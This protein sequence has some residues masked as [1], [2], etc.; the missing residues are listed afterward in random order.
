[1]E[2]TFGRLERV[3]LRKVWEKE[4][5]DF[6]PWLAQEEH[7]QNLGNAIGIELEFEAQEKEVGLFRA[8]ILCKNTLDNS[9]VLTV[10]QLED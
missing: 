8:D 9:W 3:D 6:T 2:K 10:R 1:M 5:R 4:D 7:L